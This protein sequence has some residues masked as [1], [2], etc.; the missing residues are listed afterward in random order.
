M[1]YDDC[2]FHC[3][4]CDA[5]LNDQPGFSSITGSWTC[6]ECGYEND[7]GPINTHDLL[8]MFKH[9]ITEFIVKSPDDD[10]D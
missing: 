8:D 2:D 6:S 4:N 9:G 5:L 7:V 1:A 3:D 10:D